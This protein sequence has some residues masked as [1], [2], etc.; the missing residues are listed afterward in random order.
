MIILVFT[1]GGDVTI[2]FA[3]D[4]DPSIVNRKHLLRICSLRLPKPRVK[5]A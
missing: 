1:V 4:M 5:S 3:G 2:P